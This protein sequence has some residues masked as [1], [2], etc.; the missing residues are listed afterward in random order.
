VR[1]SQ[2]TPAVIALKACFT[3]KCM[4]EK[5]CTNVFKSELFCMK[6]C[7]VQ[8]V[9]TEATNLCRRSHSLLQGSDYAALQS[10]NWREICVEL[11]QKAPTLYVLLGTILGIEESQNLND[12][13]AC[14]L[15]FISSILLFKRCQRVSRVQYM[16]GLVIDQCGATDEIVSLL[17]KVGVSVSTSSLVK[18][19]KIIQERHNNFL[20][21][22]LREATM[23]SANLLNGEI[24][25]QH[26][27]IQTEHCYCQESQT[28]S[29]P[30]LSLA[31][32]PKHHQH[33]LFYVAGDNIDLSICPT[34]MTSMKQRK[35]LHWFLAMA[36]AKRITN[37]SL[38]NVR[39][40]SDIRRVAASAWILNNEQQLQM[41]ANFKHHI[42]QIVLK[43]S[44]LQFFDF[45]APVFITHPYL[46]ESQRPSQ[47]H[48]THLFDAN[49]NK[50]ED[51]IRILRE[52][53]D[54]FVAR[55]DNVHPDVCDHVDFAGDVLTTDRAFAA[56][57]AMSN[58]K[59]SYD[60]L[61]G[62]N[63]RPGGLH[64][65]MNLCVVMST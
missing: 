6:E 17:N 54:A 64:L 51:M 4:S 44:F 29:R 43:L 47:F 27:S 9:L 35:S 20:L 49:E 33:K 37:Q 63:F 21:S 39:P 26:V 50:S 56:Q 18:Q 36:I 52:L 65:V 62:M 55:P 1:F 5:D 23:A 3:S 38:P 58:G 24:A 57:C 15:A 11:Q 16:F 28:D 45:E 32:V 48:L 42:L 61:A 19:K 14:S 8:K 2:E 13:D 22:T 30:T 7:I 12:N 41:A 59:G 31:H 53:H 25:E 60:S 40:Q 34:Y 46:A 10:I